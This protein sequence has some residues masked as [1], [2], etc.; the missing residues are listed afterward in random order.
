MR[1]SLP[2]RSKQLHTRNKT[3]AQARNREKKKNPK[4]KKHNAFFM[5][6]ERVWDY[7]WG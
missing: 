3:N 5:I 4:D 7:L 1:F 6:N 2:S